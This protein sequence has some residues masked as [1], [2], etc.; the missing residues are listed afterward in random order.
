MVRLHIRL[1]PDDNAFCLHAGDPLANGAA[2]QPDLASES[3]Q[4]EPGILLK[5]TQY[6]V[7]LFIHVVVGLE[8]LRA[9]DVGRSKS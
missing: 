5:K 1:I 7:V 3:F 6:L 9:K 4:G 2:C 8:M